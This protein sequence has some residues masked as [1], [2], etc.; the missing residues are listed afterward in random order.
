MTVLV[1]SI[2]GAT[3]RR[4]QRERIYQIELTPHDNTSSALTCFLHREVAA[5]KAEILRILTE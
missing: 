2:C 5:I 3:E 1:A 4:L